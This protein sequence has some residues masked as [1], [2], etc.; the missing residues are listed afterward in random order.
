M[1]KKMLIAGTVTALTIGAA[2]T[3]AYAQDAREAQMLGYHQLCQQGDR[4]ACIRFGMMLQ[5]NKDHMNAWRR[6]HP[7]WFWWER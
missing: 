1:L 5:Q 2:G 6:S 7:D 3:A 4:K